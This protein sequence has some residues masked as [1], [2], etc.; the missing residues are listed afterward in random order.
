[1]SLL[2]EKS[3]VG[4]NIL[5]FIV[6]VELQYGWKVRALRSDRGGEFV[7]DAL[8]RKLFEHGIRHELTTTY[9]PQLNGVAERVNRALMDRAMCMVLQSNHGKMFW[10]DDIRYAAVIINRLPRQTLGEK[11]PYEVSFGK[12][13]VINRLRV[14]GCR[15]FVCSTGPRDKLADHSNSAVYLGFDTDSKGYRFWLQKDQRLT[16]SRY[17]VFDETFLPPLLLLI[18][19]RT[20]QILLTK[21]RRGRRCP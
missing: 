14:F 17:V 7:N 10:S 3:G 15:V 2:R 21:S 16:F 6:A 12:S 18:S 9:T 11:F 1:M 5:N 8:A 4:D 13:P 20:A 19:L